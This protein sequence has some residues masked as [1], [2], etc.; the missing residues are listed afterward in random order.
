MFN[1][2]FVIAYT[3]AYTLSCIGPAILDVL[4]FRLVELGYGKEK[5]IPLLLIAAGPIDDMICILN[6]ELC[7]MLAF[8]KIGHLT[9]K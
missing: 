2:P 1:L 9:H 7:Q 4:M 5:G 3:L 8:S 6:N